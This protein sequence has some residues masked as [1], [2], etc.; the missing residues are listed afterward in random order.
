MDNATKYYQQYLEEKYAERQNEDGERIKLEFD[1]TD[2][3][4][5][6]QLKELD[7]FVN[8]IQEKVKN[9]EHVY[10]LEYLDLLL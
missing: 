9:D 10:A 4:Y 7:N 2:Q 6:E 5:L 3:E 1:N 8:L